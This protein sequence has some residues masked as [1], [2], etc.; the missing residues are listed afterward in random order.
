MDNQ[1]LG[2]FQ[3]QSWSL[4]VHVLVQQRN[5]LYYPRKKS[6]GSEISIADIIEKFEKQLTEERI[7]KIN[8][9]FWI[10]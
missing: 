7:F 6:Y 5:R 8:N 4:I 2:R 9:P 10:P 1:K 3:S